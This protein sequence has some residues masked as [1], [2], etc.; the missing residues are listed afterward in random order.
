MENVLIVDD[1]K[2]FLLSLTDGLAPYSDMFK[3]R[4]ALNGEDA[5]KIL[6]STK[7]D[8]VLT[9]LKMPKVDGFVLLS[10][11]NRHYPEMPV[12]VMTAFG[13]PDI[14]KKLRENGAC[15]YLEKPLDIKVLAAEIEKA[16]AADREGAQGKVTLPMF[17]QL[18]KMQKKTCTLGIKSG[19][20][21]GLFFL[22]KGELMDANTGYLNGE[23]A[24]YEMLGWER[25]QIEIS[26]ICRREDRVIS[27]PL[28]TILMEALSGAGSKLDRADSENPD[29]DIVAGPDEPGDDD[30]WVSFGEEKQGQDEQKRKTKASGGVPGLNAALLEDKLKD[31]A[32]VEGFAGAGVFAASGKA[33]AILEKE[34]E[35]RIRKIGPFA[36][37]VLNNARKAVLKMGNTDSGQLVHL[38]SDDMQ[39][40]VKCVNQGFG[41]PKKML[42]NVCIP[43]VMIL[44]SGNSLGMGKIMVQKV[45]ADLA[46]EILKK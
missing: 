25:V 39:I 26:N 45:A 17:L 12:I 38:E 30:D 9:D 18:V 20:R 3:V 31:L 37:D 33:L 6:E 41:P 11:I 19:S 23:D 36:K 7:I 22:V 40:L 14:E 10:Y 5:V 15:G 32:D 24:A 42:D 43:L 35:I 28:D 4:T 29:D 8:L 21:T 2:G 16:L 13:N 34:K 1:E 27:T 44:S 46:R